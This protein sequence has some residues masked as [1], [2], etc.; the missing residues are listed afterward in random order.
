M[1]GDAALEL[2]GGKIFPAVEKL[3]SDRRSVFLRYCQARAG[4]SRT[5]YMGE[6]SKTEGSRLAVLMRTG[7]KHTLQRPKTEYCL[8]TLW[9][10]EVAGLLFAM[11]DSLWWSGVA[12]LGTGVR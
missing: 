1:V 5:L 4:A 6:C 7:G 8:F 2:V 11:A 9:K 12:P 3:N 10:P